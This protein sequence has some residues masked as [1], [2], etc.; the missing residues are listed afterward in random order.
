MY[1]D[2]AERLT[3]MGIPETERKIANKI[4]RRFHS[5]VFHS[6]SYCDRLHYIAIR[7][8][9]IAAV[10]GLPLAGECRAQPYNGTSDQGA[11]AKQP[12]P[13]PAA[14]APVTQ[15]AQPVPVAEQQKPEPTPYDPH[16][17]S[18]KGHD[19]SDL[20]EQRRMSKAA[21]EAAWWAAFQ[22]K[23][24]LAGFVAVLAS[25]FFTGRAAHAAARAA[26]AAEDALK[27]SRESSEDQIRPYVHVS[28]AEFVWDASGV[29]VVIEC[30]NSG[31][32][33]ARYFEIGA[34][35][36]AVPT[37]EMGGVSIPEDLTYKRWSALGGG[38][39]KTIAL[40]GQ[41]VGGEIDPFAVHARESMPPEGKASF[42]ILGRVRYGDVF[43]SEYETEFAFFL[44]DA[45]P[46]N[47]NP[48]RKMM[49][50]PGSFKAFHMTKRAEG[51]HHRQ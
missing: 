1:R 22:S 39:A 9:L 40:R 25:L 2:L 27:I 47:D 12:A 33:P 43:G 36:E 46:T 11:Q 26:R 28:S 29:K 7:V 34:L 4:S 17:D 38:N 5:S 35:S 48:G 18:P 50:P 8:C 24:G 10:L 32:T 16:C 45:R 19:E 31:Q 15:Q 23:L 51:D 21:E 49:S 30:S 20:C 14:P 3:T 41:S 42:Y 13:N 37:E 44:R 6:M